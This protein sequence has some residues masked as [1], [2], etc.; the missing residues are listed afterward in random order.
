MLIAVVC[1]ANDDPCVQLSG[2]QADSFVH[3]FHCPQSKASSKAVQ[4][5]TLSATGTGVATGT[6]LPLPWF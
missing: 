1:T 6:T 2:T 5:N 4:Q 3:Q